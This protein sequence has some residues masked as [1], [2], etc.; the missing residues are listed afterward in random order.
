MLRRVLTGGG[1][2][3]LCLAAAVM[4]AAPASAHL[5]IRLDIRAPED[6]SKVGPRVELEV[7]AQPT[8][9]G[10][11]HTEFRVIVDGDS[12]DANTGKRTSSDDTTTIAVSTTHRTPLNLA[13]GR[14][15]VV[16]EYRPDI[17]EPVRQTAVDFQV[18]QPA[19][20]SKWTNALIAGAVMV[21]V[22]TFVAVRRVRRA[23]PQV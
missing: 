23:H 14:H 18:R 13:P 22:A 17:D 9:A 12:V 4:A 19:K 11:D 16:V 2:V 7:F 21:I 20:A 5:A 10:V 15:H 1:L 8:L 6:G 3:L